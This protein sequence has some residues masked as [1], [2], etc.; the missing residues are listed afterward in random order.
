MKQRILLV[1]D[2]KDILQALAIFFEEEGF[3]V[4]TCSNGLEVQTS[5]EKHTPD[6]ILLDLLLSGTDGGKITSVLKKS[7]KTKDIPVI[8]IS[9]HPKAKR[10]ALE[11]GADDFIAK[12]FDLDFL[13]EKVG[14]SLKKRIVH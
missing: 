11:S 13:L 2:D 4:F 14:S 12:P 9:A 3:L 10:K 1:D 8:I 6:I 5:A 7:A